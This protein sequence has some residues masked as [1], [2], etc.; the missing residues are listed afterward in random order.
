MSQDK[1][2]E[3]NKAT[4]ENLLNSFTKTRYENIGGIMVVFENFS[5]YSKAERDEYPMSDYGTSSS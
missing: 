5:T 4:S 1:I 2:K 3:S